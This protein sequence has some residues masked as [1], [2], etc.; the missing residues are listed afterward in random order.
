MGLSSMTWTQNGPEITLAAASDAIALPNLV[1]KR[2]SYISIFAVE[3]TEG[4]LSMNNMIN[5]ISTQVYSYVRYNRSSQRTDRV[6]QPN[7]EFSGG[8]QDSSFQMNFMYS[9]SNSPKIG[10]I[11]Q[12]RQGAGDQ[13]VAPRRSVIYW[14]SDLSP[15]VNRLDIDNGGS[16]DFSP[17][18]NLVMMSSN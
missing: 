12:I 10:M 13:T 18:F 9:E 4:T 1:D 3:N 6:S 16:G 17:G 2:Y 11:Y 14:K 5:N 7:V 15:S 8:T